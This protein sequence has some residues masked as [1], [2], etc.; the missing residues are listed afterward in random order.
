M[1]VATCTMGGRVLER[2]GAQD[3]LPI[4]AAGKWTAPAL[5]HPTSSPSPSPEP[6]LGSTEGSSDVSG[7]RQEVDTEVKEGVVISLDAIVL[8]GHSVIELGTGVHLKLA[9]GNIHNMGDAQLGQLA[10]VPGCV[11][12]GRAQGRLGIGRWG[13]VSLGGSVLAG[14]SPSL[15]CHCHQGERREQR[16]G[17]G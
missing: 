7:N 4:R 6:T 11:P 16:T 1:V 2:F 3:T 10:L 17:P 12:G 5:T 9:R 13:Q 8:Q 14:L 15:L